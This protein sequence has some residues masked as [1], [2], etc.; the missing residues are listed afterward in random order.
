MTKK[1]TKI[2]FTLIAGLVLVSCVGEKKGKTPKCGVGEEFNKVSQKC[3]NVQQ[4][5]TSTLESMEVY[6]DSGATSFLLKYTDVNNDQA[7]D[8]QVF[9]TELN[10]EMR[11]PLYSTAQ[12]EAQAI[13]TQGTQC[14]TSISTATHPTERT[15]AANF[16]AIAQLAFE[17]ILS[18]DTTVGMTSALSGFSSAISNL[19]TYCSGLTGV[20][21]G[22]YY[23]GVT[24]ALNTNIGMTASW[25][26]KRCSCAAGFC[27]TELVPGKNVTGSFGVSYNI[28]EGVD[29]TSVTKPVSVQV[30]AINDLPVAVDSHSAGLEATTAFSPLMTFTIPF[31]QDIE[32]SPLAL[33]YKIA[34][35]PVNGLILGCSLDAGLPNYSTGR[36]C[37]YLPASSDAGVVSPL[38]N[39]LATLSVLGDNA[40]DGILYT[41]RSG[42][43][44]G[45]GISVIYSVHSLLNSANNVEVSVTGKNIVVGIE[46]GT[47][48]VKAIVDAI[49]TDLFASA[50][51]TATSTNVVTENT[52]TQTIL[53]SA[54]NFAGSNTPFDSFTYTVS[55]GTGVS[56]TEGRITLDVEL[57]DDPPVAGTLV[58][59][60]FTEDQ[61]ELITLVYTDAESD[62]GTACSITLPAITNLIVKTACSCTVGGLCTATIRPKQDFK[63]TVGVTPFYWTVTAGGLT[64]SLATETHTVASVNDA[65]FAKH[66]SATMTESATATAAPFSFAFHDGVLPP[67]VDIEGSVLKYELEGLNGGMGTGTLT[68]CVDGLGVITPSSAATC[69]FTPQDGNINGESTTNATFTVGTYANPI[70]FTAL[71][72]GEEHNSVVVNIVDN[73]VAPANMALVE[74]SSTSTF[75]T[76]VTVEVN[77]TTTTTDDVRTAILTHPYAKELITIPAVVPA[78]I[79]ATSTA[80]LATA[81][82]NGH[83]IN[84]KVTDVDGAIGYGV[85]HISIKIED[86][87]PIACPYSPFTE[88]KECG[89]AGCIGTVTP[90]AANIT[91]KTVGIIYYDQNSAVC[92]TSSGISSSADWT[93]VTNFSTIITK[94]VV[95][96]NGSVEI[97]NIR[98]DEGGAD[99]TEDAQQMRIIDVVVSDDILLPRKAANIEF[100][101]NGSAVSLTPAI[102]AVGVAMVTA[103]GAIDAG[104]SADLQNFSIKI[105]PSDLIIGSGTVTVTI[106]DGGKQIDLIIPIEVTDSA[107]IHNGWTKI[108][109]QG[110]KVDKYGIVQDQN[111]VCNYSETKC[112]TGDSCT[113]SATPVT[114]VFDAD[115]LNAIFYDSTNQK[116]YRATTAGAGT[117]VWEAFNTYCNVTASFYDTAAC[118][119][120]ASCISATGLTPGNVASVLNTS[121]LDYISDTNYKCYRSSGRDSISWQEYDA[122]GSVTMSWAPMVITGSG[123]LSGFNIFRRMAGEDFDYTDPIN[124]ILLTS[125]STTYIDNSDNSK[126]GPIPNTVYYYEVVP[127][128]ATGSPVANIQIR[129]D[130]FE[131][132][133]IRV[134]VPGRNK[135]FVSR[136]IVNTTMCDKMA[137]TAQNSGVNYAFN[138]GLGTY[139]CN[140]EGPGDTGSV[141]GAGIYDFGKDLIVDR[142]E[143]GCPYTKASDPIE[144]CSNN[145]GNMATSG[146]CIGTIDPVAGTNVTIGTAANQVYYNRA[147]G[148]CFQYNGAWTEMNSLLWN[149]ATN[150]AAGV[151]V[152]GLAALTSNYSYS[153]LPPV[154][155]VSQSDSKVFCDGTSTATTLGLCDGAT[156]AA[157][158]AVGATGTFYYNSTSKKC[159]VSNGVAWLEGYSGLSGRLP[160]RKEQVAYSEWDFTTITNSTANTREGGLSMNSNSKCNSASA[161]GLE[162][163]Y[164]DSVIPNVSNVYTLPGT[165]SSG[166]RSMMTGSSET[167]LCSSKY[168]VQDSIGNVT[169]WTSDRMFCGAFS[170]GGT[171]AVDN[172]GLDY[173]GHGDDDFAP[174]S[175]ANGT[176]L[177]YM[178]NS[179]TGPCSESLGEGTGC[180]GYLTSWI[181]ANKPDDAKKF[182]I[183]MGLPAVE[184]SAP[185]SVGNYLYNFFEAIGS[186][187]GITSTQ[188]HNDTIIVNNEQID[189]VGNPAN[190]DGL[191]G[192]TT[193]GS[194]LHTNGAGTYHLELVPNSDTTQNTR[195]DIGFR[196]VA[197]AANAVFIE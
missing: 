101:Y 133:V 83:R 77:F 144:G 58:G 44:S 122:T 180:D 165:S 158:P 190:T 63:D 42:G 142:Y 130:Q 113:G 40:A 148:K 22:Q 46:S 191:G 114:G 6:E 43:V 98:L 107:V 108:M 38:V 183:P 17:G 112:N 1:L 194:Y 27:H 89:L 175:S 132:R 195:V 94:K 14:V 189:V 125:I 178:F 39:K 26:N 3:F 21:L 118:P 172:F 187:A 184:S 193:G 138:A 154:T 41:A 182:F 28:T 106:G 163:F 167:A 174:V 15:N 4:A 171:L 9:D 149:D 88:A 5:P 45:H 54:Q 13:I 121:I 129:T 29:G 79:G 139:T 177:R 87:T 12:T 117:T 155:N 30:L 141:A 104:A 96:Q 97:K 33:S 64:S 73:G 147:N 157:V 111:F 173:I 126:F 86:D 66:L 143:A 61:D 188:L 36:S 159:F 140:Y 50:I 103:P 10:I 151:S 52:N 109:A 51:I 67:G 185:I 68:G 34:T 128:V 24:A 2:L 179:D 60:T 31:G 8:C 145:T 105:T 85:F 47:T 91:P 62:L 115:E 16:L 102:P 75:V 72:L 82:A 166:I 37:V 71:H 90:T 116:C 119:A 181:Y 153:A 127:V 7:I 92:Y 100:F 48:T 197:P 99:A 136:D 176:F 131:K 59:I 35:G 123:S 11:S 18:T 84:Y 70:T 135:T 57:Q 169:E 65:P 110:P 124:K 74:V 168:G 160:S 186:S 150:L 95:S 146:S 23:G 55:D 78:V 192:I 161:N 76:T 49:N 81:E 170:C 25:I 137:N 53:G 164:T 20:P 162:A 152:A 93:I 56:V 80:P 156:N 120:G 69:V 196:C 32:T 19:A 134:I